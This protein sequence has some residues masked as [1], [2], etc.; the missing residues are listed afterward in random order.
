M[1]FMFIL[2]FISQ[3]FSNIH[4]LIPWVNR[5]DNSLPS[6][7][8]LFLLSCS[9]NMEIQYT[10]FH[11]N[12]FNCPKKIHDNIQFINVGKRGMS[13]LFGNFFLE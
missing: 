2:F 9:K 4:I 13:I 12:I 1:M 7:I 5:K 8:D 6:Y 11:E 10:I 3:T